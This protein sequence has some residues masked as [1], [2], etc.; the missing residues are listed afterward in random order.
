MRPT[1]FRDMAKHSGAIFTEGRQPLE[2]RRADYPETIKCAFDCG[3]ALDPDICRSS[4]EGGIA[5]GPI[6][7]LLLP[8]RA[9]RIDSARAAAGQVTG[10]KRGRKKKKCAGGIRRHQSRQ[11]KSQRKR[12]LWAL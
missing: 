11:P 12:L 8:Q 1:V 5:R 2:D 10:K 4:I 9:H 3:I 6:S 7:C